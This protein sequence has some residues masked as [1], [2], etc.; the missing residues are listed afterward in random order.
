MTTLFN[1]ELLCDKDNSILVIVDIQE[2]LSSAIPEKI[3]SR[4]T[5]KTATLSQAANLLDIPVLISEQYPKG[6]GP[7]LTEVSE[8]L[9]NS[10]T[11]IE[12][13]CFSCAQNQEFLTKIK[14]SNKKQIIL[15]GM[16]AHIC[17]TQTALELQQLNYQVYIASDAI[18]SRKKSNYKNALQRLQ[19]ANCIISNSESICFEW[20]TD[21]THPQ[22][23]A[24]SKLIK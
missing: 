15:C 17:V 6:L 14:A 10:S 22:F 21:A 20:L 19:Q 18:C 11:F 4:V 13:T 12:K 3:L 24:I 7:T 9:P 5:K 23:K 8:Y 2:R 1:S 16:E